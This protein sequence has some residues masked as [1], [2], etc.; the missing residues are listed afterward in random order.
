VSE[1]KAVKDDVNTSVDVWRLRDT[2][3]RKHGDS[4]KRHRKRVQKG[5]RSC[6]GSRHEKTSR[7][8]GDAWGPSPKKSVAG[9]LK[10]DQD[11]GM[12]AGGE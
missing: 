8:A 1:E 2:R 4:K 9:V 6:L 5:E 3:S 12:P 7:R 11:A 10:G